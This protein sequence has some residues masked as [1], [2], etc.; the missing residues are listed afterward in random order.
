MHLQLSRYL[1]YPSIYLSLFS[2]SSLKRQ[3]AVMA[4]MNSMES[5]NAPTHVQRWVSS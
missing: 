2:T 3:I 1:S 4:L 5:R